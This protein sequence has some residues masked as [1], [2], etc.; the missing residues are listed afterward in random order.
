MHALRSYEYHDIACC[1]SHEHQLFQVI[2]EA[3]ADVVR[4]RAML[5]QSINQLKFVTRHM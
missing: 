4:T 3:T 1:Q 2:E 5:N